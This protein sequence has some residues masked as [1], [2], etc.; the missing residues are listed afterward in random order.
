MLKLQLSRKVIV[1]A[2]AK[3]GDTVRVH[4][5][6]KLKDGK[7][8]D[9]SQGREPLQFT[10]GEGKIIP[11]FEVA[12][13]GMSPGEKKTIELPP[14]EAY[15]HRRKEMVVE[16]GRDKMPEGVEP[17]VGQSLQLVNASG[18]ALTALIVDVKEDVVVIDGNHPLA[19]EVLIFEIELLKIV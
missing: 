9:S 2:K 14:E 4:Y 3:Q 6:G 5:T 8:F 11:G 10:L 16:I 13:A 1:M 18:Q 7:V 19:G 15:G 17:Q 12:V